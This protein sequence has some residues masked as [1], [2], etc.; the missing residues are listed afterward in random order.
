MKTV[1]SRKRGENGIA[2]PNQPNME[3]T[4]NKKGSHG[5]EKPK[6]MEITAPPHGHTNQE[7][8]LFF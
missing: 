4:V 3:Y 1:S 2:A 5:T 8:L 7:Y 6:K